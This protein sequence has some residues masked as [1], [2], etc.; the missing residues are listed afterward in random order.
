MTCTVV[1]CTRPDLSFV[2]NKLA[3]HMSKPT[4]AHMGIAK[5]V[6]RYLKGTAHYGLTFYK[7]VDMNIF[8]F[9]DS[10]WGNLPDRRSI[11]GYCFKMIN[12]S[13]PI[14]WRSKKQNSVALSSC[15]AE[16]VSMSY[17]VQEAKFLRQLL[18]VVV[19]G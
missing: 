6:L 12:L 19:V 13:S 17:A 4:V 16:Y 3:Q 1:H 9:C 8:G 10:D 14:S 11:A 18:V 5:F 15:E 7:C 2:V